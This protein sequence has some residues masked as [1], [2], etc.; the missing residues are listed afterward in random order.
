MHRLDSIDTEIINGPRHTIA[1]QWEQICRQDFSLEIDFSI[2]DHR[3]KKAQKIVQ[4]GLG[5]NLP[6]FKR[7]FIA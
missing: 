4:P 6:E 5:A 2:L 3:L 1:V 7:N